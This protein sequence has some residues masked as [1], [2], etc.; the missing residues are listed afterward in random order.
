MTSP[1]IFLSYASQDAEAARRIRDALRAAGLEVWFDQSELRGGDAWDASIRK[2][3]KE[4]ALFVPMISANT[5]AREEGY[6]RL[7]WKLAV[8]RSHLMADNKA[9]FVP[10]ILGDVSEPSALVPDKFR[11]RQWSR[12]NDDQSITAFAARIGK[13]LTGSGAPGIN[14]P[15]T[16]PVLDF[17]PAPTMPAKVSDTPSIAV[18]AFANRSA[19]ADDEYF[20][21]GLADELLNVLAK[22][23]GLRV[24][25]RTSAFSF[26]GKQSTVAEI[27]RALN[28]VTVL[29]GSVRKS[30]NRARI[31]VQLVKVEDGFHLWS[32][33]YD[34][35]LDDIFA[36]QD[37]IA[38]EVVTALRK[39]LFGEAGSAKLAGNVSAELA[40][41][42]LG[43]SENSE[44]H[45]LIMQ[46]R[47]LMDRHS[48]AELL[49]GIKYLREA[50][51]ADP[52]YALAWAHLSRALT[53]AGAYGFADVFESN[54]EALA[55]AQRA[56]Q[57]APDLAEGHLALC[58]H[59]VMYGWDWQAARRHITDGLAI[60]PDNAEIL[61]AA[62]L[63]SYTLGRS[64]ESIA[65]YERALKSDPM[66]SR[67]YLDYTRPLNADLRF[68]EAER[69]CRRALEL[70]PDGVP[71]H[72]LLAESL[73]LQGRVDEAIAE[74]SK[75]KADWARL[76][77]LAVFHHMA[78]N[79]AESDLALN[80]LIEHNAD[81]SAAQIVCIYAVRGDADAAFLWLERGYA[82][83][84]SGVTHLKAFWQFQKLRSDPRWDPMLKK[85]G[86]DG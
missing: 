52:H 24:A 59:Q 64:T 22:I 51:I 72:C 17:V 30:G 48:G 36:V 6:F 42:T 61:A 63:L 62:G 29:E 50:L 3:I 82:Q 20:S 11:E 86:L 66:N 47:H 40:S 78:G 71:Y 7:E 85:L 53:H 73:A 2:Q 26:K 76:W 14:A 80:T 57:L 39:T 35:T 38:Q 83:R 27:G 19:S 56:L 49:Q 74:A 43:R 68:A 77:G 45:R 32:E 55:A 75:E 81:H 79:R 8:D 10:V 4:C 67:L 31:S 18:L 44:A 69:A 28:V 21:D 16:A 65:Y 12:L 84:D 13:L 15:N 60:A 23:S 33:T 37:E 54:A 46:A 1:A 5:N 34:R 41:A 70:S 9:F 25:A 58:M